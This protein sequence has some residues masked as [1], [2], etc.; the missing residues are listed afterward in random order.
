MA[1]I[2][3]ERQYDAKLSAGLCF[4]EAGYSYDIHVGALCCGR[5]HCKMR[6]F[7]NIY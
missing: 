4:S 6:R 7:M 5:A 1:V 3:T 2:L